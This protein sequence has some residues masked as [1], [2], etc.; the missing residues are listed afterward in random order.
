[1]DQLRPTQ[2]RL[3][4]LAQAGCEAHPEEAHATKEKEENFCIRNP[5]FFQNLIVPSHLFFSSLE[6]LH[7]KPCSC[8]YSSCHTLSQ[9]NRKIRQGKK[10]SGNAVGFDPWPRTRAVAG[11]R[12]LN[13]DDPNKTGRQ[14]ELK[15]LRENQQSLIL[16]IL[17]SQV[18]NIWGIMVELSHRG[19]QTLCVPN[20]ILSV[21]LQHR[22]YRFYLIGYFD[23][24]MA[25]QQVTQSLG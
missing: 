19:I 12:A 13:P 5:T 2:T 22:R 8:F 10:H 18:Q 23:Q 16:M 14:I 6:L 4:D 17:K 25:K 1:M 20:F 3:P 15:S 21:S 7:H 9:Q 24:M 11:W